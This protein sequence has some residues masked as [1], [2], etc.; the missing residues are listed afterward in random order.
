M[1]FF[2][3]DQFFSKWD[4][5]STHA[6]L[7]ATPLT[8]ETSQFLNFFHCPQI[9]FNWNLFVSKSIYHKIDDTQRMRC[10]IKKQAI[11]TK[12]EYF[13]GINSIKEAR[14]TE[15]NGQQIMVIY[16]HVSVFF[17]SPCPSIIICNVYPLHIPTHTD[18]I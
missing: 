5:K 11:T 7:L 2:Y 13:H 15:K 4:M 3:L 14:D 16:S 12:K 18:T 1:I 10:E 9:H 8:Q 6:L 17:F